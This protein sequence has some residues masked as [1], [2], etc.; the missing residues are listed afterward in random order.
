MES[1]L[2]KKTNLVIDVSPLNNY[3]EN[4]LQRNDS[5]RHLITLKRML[6]I[7]REL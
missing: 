4:K 6:N 5:R 1:F 3:N 7:S 2:G